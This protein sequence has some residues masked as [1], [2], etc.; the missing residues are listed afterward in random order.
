MFGCRVCGSDFDPGFRVFTVWVPV[1]VSP[2]L[3]ILGGSH[4]MKTLSSTF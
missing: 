1:L 2:W 4:P 3:G